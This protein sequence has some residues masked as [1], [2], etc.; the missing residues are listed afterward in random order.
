MLTAMVG[1]VVSTGVLLMLRETELLVSEPSLLKLPAASEN[2]SDDT[3]N[4]ALDA[5]AEGVKVAV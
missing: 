4:A 1:G 2:L 5:L 3:V